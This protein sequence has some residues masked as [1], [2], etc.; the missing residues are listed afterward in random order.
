M[1]FFSDPRYEYTNQWEAFSSLDAVDFSVPSQ[2][3]AA[4]FIANKFFNTHYEY[5]EQ[6]DT[7]RNTIFSFSDF[8]RTEEQRRDYEQMIVNFRVAERL[9][10]NKE[11]QSLVRAKY[12]SRAL[13]IFLISCFSHSYL[14]THVFRTFYQQQPYLSW[15]HMKTSMAVPPSI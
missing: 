5:E 14:N 12:L 9:I 1:I 2:A 15:I 13:V 10:G 6:N 7:L 11:P 4:A 3:E 8:P